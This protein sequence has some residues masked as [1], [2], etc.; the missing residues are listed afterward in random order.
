MGGGGGGVKSEMCNGVGISKSH[1]LHICF[2]NVVNL[3]L[4]EPIIIN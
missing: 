1:V 4:A 3:L 2:D